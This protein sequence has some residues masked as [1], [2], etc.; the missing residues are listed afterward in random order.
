MSD[1]S[2]YVYEVT[3]LG[4]EDGGG[5]LVTFPDCPGVIGIGETTE[6][7]VADGQQALF[8]CLDALKAVDREPPLPGAARAA[9]PLA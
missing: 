6:A 8:A 3:A 7:A 4:A 2:V 9:M 1:P 5:Y